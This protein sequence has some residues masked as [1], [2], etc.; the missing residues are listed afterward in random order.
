M[1][2]P[3]QV[4]VV[5]LALGEGLG[6]L[7]VVTAE[8]NSRVSWNPVV[9]VDNRGF[10]FCFIIRYTV[11]THKCASCKMLFLLKEVT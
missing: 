3:P 2:Q 1:L 11:D 4:V 7:G 10:I 8:P 9:D 6:R 5:R